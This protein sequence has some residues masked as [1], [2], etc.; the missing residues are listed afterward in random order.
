[1]LNLAP[2]CL[3]WI[4]WREQNSC[5]FDEHELL[6]FQLK[7]SFIRKFKDWSSGMGL[8][9]I[10]TIIEFIDSLTFACNL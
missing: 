5:T 3:M 8:N 10:L 2:L 9:Y 6:E 1:M 7:A 4:L